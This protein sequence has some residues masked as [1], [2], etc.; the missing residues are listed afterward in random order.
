MAAAGLNASLKTVHNDRVPAHRRPSGPGMDG[1][2][3]SCRRWL[4]G[5]K[6]SALAINRAIGRLRRRQPE[7]HGAPR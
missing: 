1:S 2:A 3:R 5:E 7:T 6:I 4:A